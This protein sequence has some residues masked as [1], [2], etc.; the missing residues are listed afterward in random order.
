MKLLQW[1]VWMK[2]DPDNIVKLVKEIDPDVFCGQEFIQKLD[3]NTDTARYIADK[4]GMNYYFEVA[5]RWQNNPE[6]D[7]QGNAIFAKHPILKKSY[8]HIQKLS[9]N[10][11]NAS[12]EGR[13]YLEIEIRIGNKQLVIGT[14]HLS[15]SPFFEITETRK[16]EIDNLLDLLKTKKNQYLFTADLNSPP[17]SYTVS[18]IG[19]YLKN[20]G[21]SL[22]QNTWTT[23]PFEKGGF[24]ENDLNWRLDYIFCTNDVQIKSAEVINT[25]FSDHL[26]LLTE[27]LV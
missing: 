27:I 1:N 10:P 9:G 14:T 17:D 7:A 22:D 19:R 11:K 3:Q 13:V 16:K 24:A 25:T 2:E 8:T 18:E 12:S 6:K 21:P 23:K 5:D 15:Y 20:A 26:P 4:L